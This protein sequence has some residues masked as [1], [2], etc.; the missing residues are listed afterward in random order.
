MRK[1]LI[2]IAFLLISKLAMSGGEPGEQTVN[3]DTNLAPHKSQESCMLKPDTLFCRNDDTL[4]VFCNKIDSQFVY[5]QFPLNN[6]IYKI[7]NEELIQLNS[8]EGEIITFQQEHQEVHQIEKKMSI[9]DSIRRIEVT[10]NMKIEVSKEVG[11][12]EVKYEG[13]Y[14][15]TNE[16]LESNAYMILRRK[17]QRMDADIVYVSKKRIYRE[18]G[19]NPRIEIKAIAYSK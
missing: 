7:S 4:L 15:S 18:F 17:A 12:I 9:E 13:D 19:E 16:L 14:D 2:S 5:Y 3:T 11:R 8:R 6:K 1:A 10:T